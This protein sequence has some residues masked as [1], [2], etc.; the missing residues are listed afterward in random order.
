MGKKA[1]EE[2]MQR[3][4]L[5]IANYLFSETVLAA[6]EVDIDHSSLVVVLVQGSQQ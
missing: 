6:V 1:A 4:D 5:K 2:H 3:M